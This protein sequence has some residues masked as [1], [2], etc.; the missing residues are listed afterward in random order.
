MG[1]CSYLRVRNSIPGTGNSKCKGPEAGMCLMCSKNSQEA[2]VARA[3]PKGDKG[4]VFS[5]F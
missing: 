3:D 2:S 5:V 1:P 4:L